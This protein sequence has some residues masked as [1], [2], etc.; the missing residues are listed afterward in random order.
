M[1]DNSLDFDQEV[2]LPKHITACISCLPA[3][4]P[5]YIGKLHIEKRWIP[6]LGMI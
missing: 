4:L 3:S 6:V 5:D 1:T 2:T